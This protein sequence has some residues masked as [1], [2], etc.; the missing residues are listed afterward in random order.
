MRAV[1][2]FKRC[3]REI[4]G[5]TIVFYKKDTVYIKSP[6]TLAVYHCWWETRPYY[7]T[8]HWQIFTLGLK[9]QNELDQLQINTLAARHMVTVQAARGMPEDWGEKLPTIY[10]EQRRKVEK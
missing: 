1:Q 2:D 9:R 10:K 6:T 3:Y 7:K 5:F 8:K 4:N